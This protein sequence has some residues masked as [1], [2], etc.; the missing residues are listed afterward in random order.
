M[1]N[2]IGPQFNGDRTKF[3]FPYLENLKRQ[4]RA[5]NTF[6]IANNTEQ[7][8]TLDISSSSNAV[9]NTYEL[10][11][12]DKIDDWEKRNQL[13]FAI[14][15]SSV[16]SSILLKIN[17]VTN[18]C[19]EA[20]DFLNNQFG[21]I[22]TIAEVAYL[23]KQLEKRKDNDESA[24]VF[25][26]NW[27]QLSSQLGI[28]RS[29]GNDTRQLAKLV[30]LFERDN[31]YKASI[32]MAYLTDK[33]LDE[34]ITLIIKEDQKDKL[35]KE[36]PSVNFNTTAD[37][38]INNSIL[39]IQNSNDYSMRNRDNSPYRYKNIYNTN[40]S[41]YSYNR[42]DRSRSRERSPYRNYENYNNER[43]FSYKNYHNNNTNNNNN[44]NNYINNKRDR[45]RSNSR[46]RSA[47]NDNSREKKR[48]KNNAEITSSNTN[49]NKKP[50]T[51]N[52][53]NNFKSDLSCWNFRKGHC[54]Y[55]DSCKFSHK[56]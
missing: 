7:K 22:L 14:I 56:N 32:D 46:N 30:K 28:T 12:M 8:P 19:R 42:N 20:Y 33:N 2:W 11:V 47:S 3:K 25:I 55:G 34:T 15:T 36:I 16:T 6:K 54:K 23:E 18:E 31:M 48:F 4:L 1:M 45:E 26:E 44:K 53:S 41:N 27:K 40:K 13:G 51:E 9:P 10:R 37:P 29:E 52:K 50:H 24:E 43:N 39:R 49:S 35:R 21:G 17:G 38:Q 5:T